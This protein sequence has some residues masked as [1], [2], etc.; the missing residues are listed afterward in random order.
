M[1]EQLPAVMP[2][3]FE[4]WCRRFDDLFSRQKQRQGFRTY[5]GGLLGE[6]GR[7]NLA[8]IASNTVEGSY[9]S[10]RHFLN[11]APWNVE[12]LNNRRLE[13]M[14]QCRQTTPSRGFTLIV[15]DSGHRKSGDTTDGVGRQ[16]IGEIGKTDN[17]IVLLSTHLYDGVRRLPLD[18]ALYQHAS[19]LAQGKEDP[20]FIKK[21]DLAVQLIDQCLKRGYRPGVTLVDA[22][23]GNNTPFIKQL[24]SRKLIYVAAVAKNRR[25][26]Y[27]LP[28]DEKP[29][30]HSLTEIT[31]A[32]AVEEFIPVLLS[33]DNP[34]T[35]WVATI[36][37]QVPQL[38]GPRWIAIQLNASTWQAATEVDYFLTNASKQHVTAEWIAQ[39][40]SQ[41]NWVEVFYREAKGWFGLSEYQV[42]DA[43]SMKRHWI[44]VF[45]A[46][47]F[48][49]WHQ[50]TGGV[51][52]R[53]ATKPLQT[54]SETLEAFRTAVE[55]RFIRWLNAHLDVFAAH[56]A[57][58]GY[59]WA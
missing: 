22:G 50:L 31:Q 58:S 10:L 4:N 39:T 1:K 56:R 37:V 5:L 20:N 30:K 12:Q 24:E 25:V 7:K 6:S 14:S 55:F 32:L 29:R 40:Y 45:T 28:S 51:R 27:Q 19:S 41:R 35:V 49:L 2:Q 9:N 54:I 11:E 34:R 18:V 52:R 59:V 57:K 33:L 38:E 8:Q 3:C 46:Y 26:T 47:T 53:W 16:Y 42:R 21:P 17:G 43:K 36:Q 23:Y 15:D 13:V 44:L 48:I